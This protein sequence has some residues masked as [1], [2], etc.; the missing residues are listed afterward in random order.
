MYLFFSTDFTEDPFNPELTLTGHEGEMAQ[1]CI[2]GWKE[3]NDL[4]PSSY[5]LRP[6]NIKVD[7]KLLEII[8]TAWISDSGASN[9]VFGVS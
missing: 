4:K 8:D 6:E 1:M 9:S 3:I 2:W 7:Y 5:H